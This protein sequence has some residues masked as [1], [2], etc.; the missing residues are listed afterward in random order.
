[1]R[2][3]SSNLIIFAEKKVNY[4]FDGRKAVFFV[5]AV[6]KPQIRFSGKAQ[7]DKKRSIH[8]VSEYF[9]EDCNAANET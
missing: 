1:M 7:A 6:S 3:K 5:E 2:I 8:G 4:I 9:E